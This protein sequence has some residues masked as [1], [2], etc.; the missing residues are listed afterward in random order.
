MITQSEII[1][2][3]GRYYVRGSNCL[4]VPPHDL[5]RPYIANYTLSFPTPQSMPD[6]YTI[7][8]SASATLTVACD[9]NRIVSGLRGVNTKACPVGV[10]ANKMKQ[11]LLIEFR[12]G[13]LYPFIPADQQEIL[14]TSVALD[15]LDARLG[16]TLEDA[17]TGA[18]S[19]QAL[20]ETLDALFLSLLS[21]DKCDR[22]T[23]AIMQMI[24]MRS[25]DVGMRELANEVYYSPKHIRRLF[26]LHVGTSPKTFARVVRVNY[27][28]RIMQAQPSGFADIAAQAGYYDQPH[29]VHEFQTI[30]G[31][32]PWQYKQNMSVYYN[33][34][35]KM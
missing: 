30:C 4:Y 18:E 11:L 3:Q 5:L 31:T 32:T 28:L 17:L 2:Y 26:M 25:G 6:G 1:T 10:Y 12:P 35:F 13:G 8:P 16:H 21:N 24:I 22:R 7:L 23:A 20:I 29:L 15:A 14:D 34:L 9:G 27:A 33:D 19:V